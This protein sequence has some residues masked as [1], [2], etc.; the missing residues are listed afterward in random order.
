MKKYGRLLLD[1]AMNM[2]CMSVLTGLFAGVIVTFYNILMSIGEGTSEQLYALL[3]DNPAFIP[4]LFAGLAAGAV[5]IGTLVRFVPMIRG[6][7]IPQIEGAARGVIRFKWYVTMCSMFAAS[8]ACV[9][10]GI[11]ITYGSYM[12]KQVK[13]ESSVHQIEVFD[14]GIAILSGLMIIPAAYTFSGGNPETLGQGPGLMF[15]ALPQVFATFGK[16]GGGILGALFFAL[17]L[18]AALTSAISLMETVVSIVIDK[19]HL[20]RKKSS[21]IVYAGTLL[22]GIPSALGFGVLGKLS[23]KGMTI[24]DM[25]D[26]LSNSVLMPIA[27][28][29][30]CIF[31]GYIIGCRQITEEIE[32][33]G[34]F[35]FKKFFNVMIKY[36]CPICIVAILVTSILSAFGVF[37]I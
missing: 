2:F 14:T 35:K 34:R 19:F 26:F 22:L 15:V 10:M 6:S 21:L 25:F 32:L 18:F 23:I 9:F 5:L 33:N 7:G 8:L 3:S 1:N 30:T 12:K 31:I 27:A 20:S 37:N 29:L 13:I 11:M 36:I 16:V 28:L 24:L 17:V 4:L